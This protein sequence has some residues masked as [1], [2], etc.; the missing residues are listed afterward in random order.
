M[1]YLSL[2]IVTLCGHQEQ[3]RERQ[4][5]KFYTRVTSSLNTSTSV[6]NSLKDCLIIFI[7]MFLGCF[8]SNRQQAEPY[9]LVM[10]EMEGYSQCLLVTDNHIATEIKKNVAIALLAEYFNIE[11]PRGC[12]SFFIFLEVFLL[13]IDPSRF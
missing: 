8:G 5:E 9:I 1:F 10:G 11:Y 4:L 13:L 6:N 2:T 7:K 12:K 3:Q